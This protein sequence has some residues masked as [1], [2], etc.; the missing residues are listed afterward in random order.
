MIRITTRI[1]NNGIK[2]LAHEAGRSRGSAKTFA[3]YAQANIA[4]EQVKALGINARIWT[5]GRPIYIAIEN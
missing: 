1:L 2:V 5:R 3:N 4:L